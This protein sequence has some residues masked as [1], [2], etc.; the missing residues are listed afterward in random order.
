M[1][2]FEQIDNV[3]VLDEANLVGVLVEKEEETVREG[4]KCGEGICI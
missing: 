3:L 1:N 4:R 2:I